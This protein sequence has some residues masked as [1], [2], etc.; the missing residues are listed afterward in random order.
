MDRLDPA[1]IAA[2][3]AILG[4]IITR[5]I[6][7]R[8]KQTELKHDEAAAIRKELR[9]DVT[10]LTDRLELLSKDLDTWK[11]KYY[12]L[13]DENI[14]LRSRCRA[15]EVEVEELRQKVSHTNS[16]FSSPLEENTP[17]KQ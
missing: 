17:Q 8:Q 10:H 13:A 14:I 9:E 16:G 3:G 15:L 4:G 6:V 7:G 12:K 2:I 1:S 11:D 5:V